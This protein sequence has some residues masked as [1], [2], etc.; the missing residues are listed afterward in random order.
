VPTRADR[1]RVVQGFFEAVPCSGLD[2]ALVSSGDTRFQRLFDALRDD[3]YRNVSPGTLCRRFGISWVD[4]MDLWG[5]Y[6]MHLGLMQ[7]A[8]P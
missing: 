8:N 5:R 1:D 7:V 3:L 6:N 2:E 4:P